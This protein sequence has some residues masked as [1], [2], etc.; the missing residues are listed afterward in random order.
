MDEGGGLFVDDGDEAAPDDFEGDGVD[1]RAS[2][3]FKPS[4][5][6]HRC[7]AHGRKVTTREGMN[8]A[9]LARN[10]LSFLIRIVWAVM[11]SIDCLD[12]KLNVFPKGSWRYP[13][14]LSFTFYG[15]GN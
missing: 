4:L 11:L 14:Q 9:L 13:Y 10:I 6:L 1:Q 12:L 5:G 15:F 2:S 8:G 7:E 3:Y